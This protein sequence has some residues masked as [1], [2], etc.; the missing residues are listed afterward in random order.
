MEI[1][2]PAEDLDL[3]EVAYGTRDKLAA[4]DSDKLPKLDFH[5]AD[6]GEENDRSILAVRR[7][8]SSFS[9]AHKGSRFPTLVPSSG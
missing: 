1:M 8:A 7:R 5:E 2:L 6:R 3:S 4:C 9:K